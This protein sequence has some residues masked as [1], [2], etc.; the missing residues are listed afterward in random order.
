MARRRKKKRNPAG[1]RFVIGA[2][3]LVVT[4]VLIWDSLKPAPPKRKQLTSCN[5]RPYVWNEDGVR[6]AVQGLLDAGERDASLISL[7]V[8]TELFGDYPDGG[9]VEFPP[10]PGAPKAVECVWS[11]VTWLVEAMLPKEEKSKAPQAGGLAWN[12]RTTSDWDTYPWEAP[13]RH[14]QNSVMPGTFVYAE[15]MDV[16]GLVKNALSNAVVMAADAGLD[17]SSVRGFV[18]ATSSKGRQLR[19]QMRDLVTGG[20][21]NDGLYGQVDVDKAGGNSEKGITYV[22]NPKGRG[23]NWQHYHANNLDRLTRGLAPKRVTNLKG[24]VLDPHRGSSAMLLWIPAIDL[25]LLCLGEVQP[26]K[27]SDGESTREPPPSVRALGL[28]LSNVELPGGAGA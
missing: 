4:G 2:G 9:V 8:A 20:E 6:A 24:D 1:T 22:L 27:W 16:D 12:L 19:K 14:P 15:G 10:A 13:T 5:P 26:L 11:L 28:D 7:H 18:H 25:G 17:T 21:F 23:L 3:L